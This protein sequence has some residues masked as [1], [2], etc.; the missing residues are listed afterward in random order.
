M[1]WPAYR[2]DG[3]A[4]SHTKRC[5]EFIS[6]LRRSYSHDVLALRDGREYLYSLDGYMGNVMALRKILTGFGVVMWCHLVGPHHLVVAGRY[7]VDDGVL[8]F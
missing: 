3:V 2:C 4:I 7:L 6:H 1:C 8:Y 5:L